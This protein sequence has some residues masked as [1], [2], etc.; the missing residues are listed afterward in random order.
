MFLVERQKIKNGETALLKLKDW[1]SGEDFKAM[2]PARYLSFIS[3]IL[4]SIS[5]LGLFFFRSMA[6]I[7][8]MAEIQSH[9]SFFSPQI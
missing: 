2:M 6:H 3:D 5:V 8:V 7:L 9:S 1:P 4:K